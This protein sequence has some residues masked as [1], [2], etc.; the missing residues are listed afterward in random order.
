VDAIDSAGHSVL[1]CAIERQQG[2]L[3]ADIVEILLKHGA[4]PNLGDESENKLPPLHA[5]CLASNERVV[6]L[7]INFGAELQ[8]LDGRMQWNAIHWAVAGGSQAIL[9]AL[10]QKNV[11]II[12]SP[13]SGISPLDLTKDKPEGQMLL[14]M[15]KSK[16]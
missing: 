5:A 14:N 8:K 16:F 7:L 6:G 2:S 15:L 11:P 4:N 3:A 12:K 1:L 13:K 9:Q 10:L